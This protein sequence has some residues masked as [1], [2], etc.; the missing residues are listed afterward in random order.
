MPSKD[1]KR[2][3][4]PMQSKVVVPRGNDRKDSNDNKTKKRRKSLS[5]S[6]EKGGKRQKSYSKS[7]EKKTKLQ[8]AKEKHCNDSSQELAQRDKLAKRKSPRKS[9]VTETV[10]KDDDML[11][12]TEGGERPPPRYRAASV[13]PVRTRSRSR[14][15]SRTSTK[16]VQFVDEHSHEELDYD[17]IQA[18]DVEVDSIA[19]N[20]TEQINNSAS[21]PEEGEGE[22]HEA[23][24]LGVKVAEMPK[25]VTMTRNN[26]NS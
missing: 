1:G 10:T 12:D 4:P 8:N 19:S 11:S 3:R 20:E 14:S 13:S 5:R 7:P 9:S 15:K 16:T 2:G 25:M 26:Y 24:V 6:P 17:D 18:E 22:P 23:G 21:P